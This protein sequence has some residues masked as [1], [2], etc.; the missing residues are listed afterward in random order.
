MSGL[1]EFP[2][3]AM[4]VTGTQVSLLY[5]SNSTK[6]VLLKSS[7]DTMAAGSDGK[8]KV[9]PRGPGRTCSSQL[10]MSRQAQ[11]P[12]ECSRNKPRGLSYCYLL[13]P[14]SYCTRCMAGLAWKGHGNMAHACIL[15]EWGT[16]F[17]Q[18]LSKD[19]QGSCD[20]RPP[21]GFQPLWNCDPER[22]WTGADSGMA[23]CRSC[24][25]SMKPQTP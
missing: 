4:R 23:V 2:P 3:A 24:T 9:N 5:A 25:C 11:I 12:L 8:L 6:D 7:L 18:G 19:R 15:K 14:S 21:A 16:P 20:L 22:H 1:G 17:F 13:P 10:H